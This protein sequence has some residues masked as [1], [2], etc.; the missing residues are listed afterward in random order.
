M[1][2]TWLWKGEEAEDLSTPTINAMQRFMH[3]SGSD[4][5]VLGGAR[6]DSKSGVSS[7]WEA[8]GSFC[9]VLPALELV[10]VHPRLCCSF[11]S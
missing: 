5:K 1:G 6:F 10:R 9:M 3:A 8:F 7:E 2:A 4:M 11:C